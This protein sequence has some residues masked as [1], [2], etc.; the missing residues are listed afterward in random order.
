M[1][2]PPE[3]PGLFQGN[4]SP[5]FSTTQITEASLLESAQTGHGSCSEKVKQMEHNPI[6]SWSSATDLTSFW[7]WAFGHLSISRAKRVAVFSPTPGSLSRFLISLLRA[8]GKA[9]DIS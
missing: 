7:A 9:E 3:G 1:V 2:A 5:G 8:G 4:R 6:L